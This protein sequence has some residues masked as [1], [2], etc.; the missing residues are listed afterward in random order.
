MSQ[1]L[2]ATLSSQN[3]FVSLISVILLAFE[4]NNLSL[5]VGAEQIVDTVSSGDVGRIAALFLVNFLNPILK[6]VQKTAQWTWGFLRSP[7]FWT[8]LA[9]VVLVAL[10]GLGIVFPDGAAS[11]VVDAIFT[12]EFQAIGIALVVNVFNPLYHFFF[13]RPKIEGAPAPA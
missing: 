6:L 5:G 4:L 3:F 10:S 13:D 11:G 8:Q 9:T 7:N 1:K 2:Q 12:G